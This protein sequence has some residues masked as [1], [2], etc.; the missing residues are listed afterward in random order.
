MGAD[1][2]LSSAV[3]TALSRRSTGDVCSRQ[4]PPDR[5]SSSSSIRG[6]P[7]APRRPLRASVCAPR[8]IRRRPPAV[9]TLSAALGQQQ[10]GRQQ[11]PAPALAAV[12]RARRRRPGLLSRP[13]PRLA[14]PPV[15]RLGSLAC[16]LCRR[17]GRPPYPPHLGSLVRPY[18]RRG[19]PR[20]Y[21]LGG[22]VRPCSRRGRPR[23]YRL[24][25]LVRPCSRRGIGVDRPYRLG[26]LV[27]PCCHRGRPLRRQAPSSVRI[28][29]CAAAVSALGRRRSPAPVWCRSAADSGVSVA[30]T[31]VAP[32]G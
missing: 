30:V 1:G 16:R 17:P 27:R 12:R 26:S 28:L 22:L 18:R 2:L 6:R 5:S 32:A 25:C 13:P 9:R 3:T 21:R 15:R 31:S 7:S 14:F 8:T 4:P 24:G 19:R 23:P 20:P 29:A 11:A 10:R